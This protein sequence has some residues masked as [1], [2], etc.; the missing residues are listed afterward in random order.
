MR[1]SPSTATRMVCEMISVNP[2]DAGPPIVSPPWVGAFVV[3]VAQLVER[4]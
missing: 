3:E 4:G 2:L 1:D